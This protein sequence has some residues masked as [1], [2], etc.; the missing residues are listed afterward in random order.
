MERV[1]KLVL[2][3]KHGSIRPPLLNRMAGPLGL[4]HSGDAKFLGRWPRL[5]ELL[6]P[7]AGDA[8]ESSSN[9]TVPDSLS[10]AWK[11]V[12]KGVWNFGGI[13]KHPGKLMPESSRH[14]FQSIW[15]SRTKFFSENQYCQRLLC[16]LPKLN[17][18]SV[19]AQKM[20]QEPIAK[21][22]EGCCALLVTDPFSEPGV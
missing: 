7:W 17:T 11:L 12:E 15:D 3:L 10:G 13:R 8:V 22:P 9:S 16:R 21:W 14:L 1:R 18:C 4:N 2:H 5:L 6:A 19:K 20:G